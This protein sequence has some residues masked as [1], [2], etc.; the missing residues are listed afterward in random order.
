MSCLLSQG[1]MQ[2]IKGL[3]GLSTLHYEHVTRGLPLSRFRR[4]DVGCSLAHC[5]SLSIVAKVR[6]ESKRMHPHVVASAF[7]EMGPVRH[8]YA[9]TGVGDK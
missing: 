5:V 9:S 1:H 4:L 8:L 2:S 7:H 3:T 6:G